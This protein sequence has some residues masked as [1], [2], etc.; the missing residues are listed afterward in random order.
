[1]RLVHLR[2][3]IGQLVLNKQEAKHQRLLTIS[4]W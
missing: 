4:Q 3:E 1:M 2:I